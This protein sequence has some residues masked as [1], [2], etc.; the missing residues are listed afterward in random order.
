MPIS[1]ETT[2][3]SSSSNLDMTPPSSSRPSGVAGHNSSSPRYTDIGREH[4]YNSSEDELRYG[5]IV[6]IVKASLRK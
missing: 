5:R 6:K 2:R 1:K 3:V 4:S